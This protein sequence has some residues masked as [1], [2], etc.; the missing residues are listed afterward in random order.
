[1]KGK[2]NERWRCVN[3]VENSINKKKERK[4]KDEAGGLA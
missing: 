2:G 3:A 4:E 1:M